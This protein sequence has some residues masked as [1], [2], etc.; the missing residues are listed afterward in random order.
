MDKTFAPIVDF[1]KAINK[2]D[3]GLSNGPRFT[4]VVY[5]DSMLIYGLGPD[6]AL[7][8][9]LMWSH[10]RNMIVYFKRDAKGNCVEFYKTL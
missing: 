9:S 6:L 1:I 4:Y 3:K 5:E 10:C 2:L 8:Y 7:I